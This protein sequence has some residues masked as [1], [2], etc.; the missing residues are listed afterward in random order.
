MQLD[1]STALTKSQQTRTFR[2]RKQGL[3]ALLVFFLCAFAS[4]VSHS[5]DAQKV[6]KLIR[7]LKSKQRM[8]RVFAAVVLGK[9]GADGKR[10]VPQLART[11]KDKDDEVRM[12]AV[13]ALGKIGPVAVSALPSIFK[14]LKDPYWRVR[15]D[16]AFAIGTIG[17]SPKARKYRKQITSILVQAL[18]DPDYYVGANAAS[19]LYGLDLI[20]KQVITKLVQ[21]L[22]SESTSLVYRLD[23]LLPKIGSPAVPDLLKGLKAKNLRARQHAVI[24]LG[25]INAKEAI[26]ALIRMTR[27]K[28]FETRYFA[29]EALGKIKPS[30]KKAVRAIARSLKDKNINIIREAAWSLYNLGPIAKD[31]VPSLIRAFRKNKKSFY[32]KNY[33]PMT[34]EKLG[35]LARSAAPTMV[36]AL[37]HDKD[38]SMRS[39]C[40]RAL[41]KMGPFSKT[42]VSALIKAL[43]DPERTVRGTAAWALGTQ[44]TRVKKAIPALALALEHKDFSTCGNAAE[45]LSKMGVVA[46]PVLIHAL[47]TGT[48]PAR[49]SSVRALGKMRPLTPSAIAALK[50]AQQDKHPDVRDEAKKEVKKLSASP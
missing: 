29:V 6:R 40:M 47:K 35:P 2:Q 3:F 50:Q 31:A 8:D 44:A 18:K 15:K 25:N 45:T 12:R 16:A 22:G 13:I 4:N 38:S 48:Y 43:K 42:V 26:P 34:F 10:A 14:A 21:A 24:A 37:L 9:M 46:I 30:S 11:L 49:L 28:D 23:K 32:G 20:T 39:T 5:N 19:S 33:I 27:N 36:H 41:V 17:K 1:F 7:S